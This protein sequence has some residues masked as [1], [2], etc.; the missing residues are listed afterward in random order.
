MYYDYNFAFPIC[1]G[2]KQVYN[3]SILISLT[4]RL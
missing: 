2:K 3:S 1:I 4:A